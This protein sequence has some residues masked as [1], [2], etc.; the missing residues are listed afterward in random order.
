MG[1]RLLATLGN[2]ISGYCGGLLDS[3]QSL[4]VEAATYAK[5]A[6]LTAA[7]AAAAKATAKTPSLV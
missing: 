1:Q 7:T 3:I 5:T 4:K 2:A 6:L